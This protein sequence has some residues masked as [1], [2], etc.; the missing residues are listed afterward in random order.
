[1]AIFAVF[2]DQ[3]VSH[4]SQHWLLPSECAQA[5]RWEEQREPGGQEGMRWEARGAVDRAAQAP[6]PT[7]LESRAPWGLGQGDLVPPKFSPT[8]ERPVARG[9]GGSCTSSD[10]RVPGCRRARFTEAHAARLPRAGCRHSRA[11]P[12]TPTAGLCYRPLRALLR[13]L[14]SRGLGCGHHRAVLIFLH[15]RAVLNFS[16]LESGLLHSRAV[17][18]LPARTSRGSGCSCQTDNSATTLER[19]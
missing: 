17:L 16:A 18:N 6:A 5:D 8:S 14:G 13:A 2:F 9:R 10:I 3:M 7:A 11:A 1:M 12:G 4:S 15:S 19:L